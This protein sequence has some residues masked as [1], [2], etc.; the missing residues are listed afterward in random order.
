MKYSLTIADLVLS[1]GL[2]IG[3]VWLC[4]G[5]ELLEDQEAL[6]AIKKLA[7]LKCT[8]FEAGECL[9][10]WKLVGK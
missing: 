5:M 6:A 7:L 9:E 3:L 2:I 4:G 10:N 8:D 1:F